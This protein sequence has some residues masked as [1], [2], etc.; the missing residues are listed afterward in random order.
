MCVA[1][2]V[3][4]PAPNNMLNHFRAT[5]PAAADQIA[6]AERLEQSFGLIKPGGICGSVQHVNPWLVVL[7]ELRS[8][9][10]RVAGTIINNQVNAMLPTIR[11][12][13]ALYGRSKMFTI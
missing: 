4:L 11:I 12:E 6:C 7:K 1:L 5:A 13:E 3:F 2:I 10:A 9:I 8:L